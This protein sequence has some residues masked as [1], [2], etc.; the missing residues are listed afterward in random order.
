[1][2]HVNIA[3]TPDTAHSA[4]PPEPKAASA[5][6]AAQAPKAPRQR[7]SI[8]FPY[9][10][11]ATGIAVAK[12]IH[13]HVGTGTCSDTQLAAWLAQSPTSSSFR[14]RLTAGRMF[15]LV[16]TDRSDAIKL[17]DLGR[18]VIDPKRVR[19][20]RARAFLHVPLY[21]AV[22]EKFK[23]GP[24]PPT[25]ALDH[26]L[27]SLGVAESL[28]DRARQTLE[29]SAEQAGYFEHGHDRLVMPGYQ[30]SEDHT[31][32]EQSTGGGGGGGD[33]G[34]YEGPRHPLIVGLFQSLPPDG[35]PWTLEDLVDWLQAA[36]YNLRFAYKLK[37]VID[38]KNA[39]P[40]Q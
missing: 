31:G 16:D 27:V 1:M 23:T 36:A 28:T 5:P 20:A 22:F 21:R 30:P 2:A 13:E 3:G 8:A 12:A 29:R 10:D 4:E 37:G 11:L 15:G 14:L 40:E 35:A 18:G 34:G 32:G 7:S 26:E 38:V 19:E 39:S 33:D 6:G 25:P 24:I 9:M 17:T